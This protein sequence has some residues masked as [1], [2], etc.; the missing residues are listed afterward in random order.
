MRVKPS[1]I[2]LMLFQ[3]IVLAFMAAGIGLQL[4]ELSERAT[5]LAGLPE[6][7]RA[8][9]NAAPIFLAVSIAAWAFS[10]VK[11]VRMVVSGEVLANTERIKWLPIFDPIIALIYIGI[12][13]LFFGSVGLLSAGVAHKIF[14]EVVSYGIGSTV[15]AILIIW[16][17][18]VAKA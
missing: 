7:H 12:A 3:S 13:F 5:Q 10:E 11:L 1:S 8:I 2:L 16:L 9:Q 4:F 14:S 15:V 18:Y 17:A 6:L